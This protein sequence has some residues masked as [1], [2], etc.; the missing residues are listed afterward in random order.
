MNAVSTV[1]FI[2]MVRSTAL[3]YKDEDFHESVIRLYGVVQ[4][5]IPS[6]RFLKFTGDGAMVA[7]SVD[8]DRPE[9]APLRA[10][11]NASK[12]IRNIDHLNY[13][14]DTLFPIHVRVGIATGDTRQ[15]KHGADDLIGKKVDLASRLCNEAEQDG[16]LVDDDT[17]TNAKLVAEDGTVIR[18]L[19]AG[20]RIALCERRLVLKGIP[21]MHGE[22]FW[23]IAVEHFVDPP[24]D[25]DSFSS[26]LVALYLR[27][28]E[29]KGDFSPAKLLECAKKD[30]RFIVAG[31]T[32]L[33]WAEIEPSYLIEIAEAR[34]L[35]L[36]F[37]IASDRA[38]QYIDP[39]QLP[40]VKGDFKNALPKF[41][42][43]LEMDQMGSRQHVWLYESDLLILD[44]IVCAELSFEFDDEDGKRSLFS[45]HAALQDINAVPWTVTAASPADRSEELANAKGAMLW[46]CTCPGG[47]LQQDRGCTAHGLHERTDVIRTKAKLL[48]PMGIAIEH[49]LRGWGEGLTSRN[50]HPRNYLPAMR[51]YLECIAE[52]RFTDVPP[53]VCVQ[54]QVSSRCSTYCTMCDHF[55][56]GRRRGKEE[57]PLDDWQR[58]FAAVA[59]CGAQTAIVSGGEPLVRDDIAILLRSVRRAGL[60][61]GLLTNGVVDRQSEAEK[62]QVFEAVATSADWVAVSVDGTESLDAKIRNLHVRDKSRT[63]AE[64]LH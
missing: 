63:R 52:S 34:N 35:R 5:V 1:M 47:V 42:T 58:I 21:V 39:D 51:P 25:D 19:E 40:T 53:P 7:Y 2:D 13:R 16:M 8:P 24:A 32:L 20:T 60:R 9:R 11:S 49:Q 23:D 33:K 37:V 62:E 44:G 29:L 54:M 48:S 10:I 31:R 41:R 26:G 12:I 57:L 14:F 28:K 22:R 45:R 15:F 18:E 43:L 61:V 64:L 3:K 17:L 59:V 55:Q 4:T 56:E 6:N 27:R 30:S 36:N 50:N 46:V 38:L